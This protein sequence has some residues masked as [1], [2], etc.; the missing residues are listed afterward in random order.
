[1]ANNITLSNNIGTIWI[2]AAIILAIW[3]VAYPG[4]PMPSAIALYGIMAGVGLT[5]MMHK[6]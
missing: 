4:D 3:A 5:M 2:L 6:D 1:M